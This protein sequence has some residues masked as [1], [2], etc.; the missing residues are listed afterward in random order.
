MD[1]CRRHETP[2]SEEKDFTAHSTADDMS[3][4]FVLVPL[5]LQDPQ[6]DMDEGQADA[7][8]AMGSHHS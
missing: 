5:V 6:G 3:F 2:G 1:I 7:A 4:M 8:H